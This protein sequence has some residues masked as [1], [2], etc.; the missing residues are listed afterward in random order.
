MYPCLHYICHVVQA[1]LELAVILPP[2]SFILSLKKS[3]ERKHCYFRPGKKTE[4]H[5]LLCWCFPGSLGVLCVPTPVLARSGV[6]RTWFKALLLAQ[7]WTG[8]VTGPCWSLVLAFVR[9]TRTPVPCLC[10]CEM[11]VAVAIKTLEI[12]NTNASKPELL[13]LCV[14]GGRGFLCSDTDSS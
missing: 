10:H 3:C 11:W 9:W 8:H 7:L 14:V 2:S 4:K 12:L 1:G 6:S 5:F 13:L